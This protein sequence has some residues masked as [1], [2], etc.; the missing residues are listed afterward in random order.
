MYDSLN[1]LS[2]LYSKLNK[3]ELALEYV[4]EASR[5]YKLNL[6]ENADAYINSLCNNSIIYKNLG[7][8]YESE[9]QL[10]TALNIISNLS[11]YN[12]TTYGQVLLNLADLY[13]DWG[14]FDNAVK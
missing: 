5:L 6:G 8:F 1:T 13:T 4:L 14:N 2:V 7:E 9:G 12:I 11:V 3:F 10:L